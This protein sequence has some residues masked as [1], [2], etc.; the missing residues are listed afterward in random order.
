MAESQ[1]DL[2]WIEHAVK[3]LHETKGQIMKRDLLHFRSIE[4]QDFM[5]YDESATEEDEDQ[6][7]LM[8]FI[9]TGDQW[10]E[11]FRGKECEA[12]KK[13]EYCHVKNS[14]QKKFDTFQET[15]HFEKIFE[16]KPL[17][18]IP[19]PAIPVNDDEYDDNDD[20]YKYHKEAFNK[21]Q[22]DDLMTLYRNTLIEEA[23]S[24]K[25]SKNE[26]DLASLSL[27]RHVQHSPSSSDRIQ[28]KRR[29]VNPSN[30]IKLK[31]SNKMMQ[32]GLG[33]SLPSF[34]YNDG[35]ILVYQHPNKDQSLNSRSEKNDD[36]FVFPY[37]EHELPNYN[38]FKRQ[39][40]ETQA[41][42]SDIDESDLQNESNERDQEWGE[43]DEKGDELEKPS[44]QV[45]GSRHL[46]S[47]SKEDGMYD[48]D[49]HH[50][51]RPEHSKYPKNIEQEFDYEKLAKEIHVFGPQIKD[52]HIEYGTKKG[53]GHVGVVPN[54]SNDRR[55]PEMDQ[56]RRKCPFD[57]YRPE[58]GHESNSHRL[59]EDLSDPE[60]T[61]A[62][63]SHQN[64]PFGDLPKR[65]ENSSKVIQVSSGNNGTHPMVNVKVELNSNNLTE[66]GNIT[67]ARIE[68]G[69]SKSKR[70]VS[71]R[72]L[73][74]LILL[75]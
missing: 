20:F 21:R 5:S 65:T 26:Q 62:S 15:S 69:T 57:T 30:E 33:P 8:S 17:P 14:G 13:K 56:L 66:M 6:E 59:D 39:D 74:F 38:L 1:S 72:Y 68:I 18:R 16:P 67:L 7:P 29:S 54:E 58:T 43:Y 64:N 25:L 4:E 47:I 31:I 70:F 52:A 73:T 28:D 51:K 55:S 50:H 9:D 19:N 49:H 24:E 63:P 75:S 44:D 48:S 46:L 32:K 42:T 71:E 37:K 60:G 35:S 27:P 10:Y 41:R 2:L 12:S 36:S 53:K 23:N 45:F 11:K 61:K 34:G 3:D 40:M 22:N